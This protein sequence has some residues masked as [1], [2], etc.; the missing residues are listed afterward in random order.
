MKLSELRALRTA[1]L[2]DTDPEVVASLASRNDSETARLYNKPTNPAFYVWKDT[3]PQDEIMQNGFDWVRV[4]N[5]SAGK[6]RIWEWLF[7]NATRSINPKKNNVRAG[8]AECW[9]GTAADNDVRLVVFGHCQKVAT[10]AEKVFASGTG[11]AVVLD[12]TGPGTTTWHGEV[13]SNDIAEALN[14]E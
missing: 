10:K 3:V 7:N 2:A 8:I 4:D 1:L 11:T 6:A 14:G 12:G 13:T 5:L 9:K